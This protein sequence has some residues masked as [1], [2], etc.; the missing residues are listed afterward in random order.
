VASGRRGHRKPLSVALELGGRPWAEAGRPLAEPARR[1]LGRQHA[2][3]LREHGAP[4]VVE[5]VV[6]LVVAEQDGVDAAER[7]GGQRRPGQLVR[8]G[9]EP[10]RVVAP[11]LVEGRVGQQP[12]RAD[13]E[14]RGRASDQCQRRSHA[15]T[16]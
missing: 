1:R 2:R 4:R 6:V 12:E 5:V 14:Q 10:E 8:P 13:L 15:S 16:R 11:R 9:A 7:L 3:H